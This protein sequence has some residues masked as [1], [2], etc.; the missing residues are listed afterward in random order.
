[1]ALKKQFSTESSTS[2]VVVV[3]ESKPDDCFLFYQGSNG[4]YV[5][6][7]PLC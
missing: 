2:N 5:F 4:E 6:L 3:D 1:M 7:E